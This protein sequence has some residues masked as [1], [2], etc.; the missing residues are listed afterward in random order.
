MVAGS[1][2]HYNIIHG[3]TDE[4][5]T[6]KGYWGSIATE[7]NVST[8]TFPRMTLMMR[9]ANTMSPMFAGYNDAFKVVI[10]KT[11]DGVSDIA[12]DD[13]APVEYYNLQG[14]RVEN[15]AAGLYIRRQGS[16]VSKVIVK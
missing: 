4:Q 5:I 9:P 6:E 12:A 7:G 14:V 11:S 3:R 13:N 8:V 2:A 10:T 16:K 15:P 1:A